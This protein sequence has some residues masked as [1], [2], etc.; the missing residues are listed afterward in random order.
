MATERLP[1]YSAA[2]ISNCAE[3]R[4][5]SLTPISHPNALPSSKGERRLVPHPYYLYAS[6]RVPSYHRSPSTSF[7]ILALCSFKCS[8]HFAVSRMDL[9]KGMHSIPAISS[10]SLHEID[11]ASPVGFQ[12]CRRYP[13]PGVPWGVMSRLLRYAD[14]KCPQQ[15]ELSRIRL[16]QVNSFH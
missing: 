6:P 2:G 8:K 4:F 11:V 12:S 13:A 16:L 1:S 10:I 15:A 9:L 7:Y 5:M 3:Q 14:L